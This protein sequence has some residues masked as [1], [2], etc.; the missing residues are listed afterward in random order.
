LEIGENMKK[1]ISAVMLLTVITSVSLSQANGPWVDGIVWLE[2]WDNPGH[3]TDNWNV[4]NP[5][6]KAGPYASDTY[7]G[8]CGSATANN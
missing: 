4:F 7:M 3:Y 5:Q 6:V 8:A 1:L 2:I